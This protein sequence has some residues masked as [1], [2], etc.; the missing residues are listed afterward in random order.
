MK[1]PH[2][3]TEFHDS[4]TL[5][6]LGGDADDHWA[7]AQRTCPACRRF[8]LTLQR[9]KHPLFGTDRNG[10]QT[11]A[12]FQPVVDER[13]VKP[14]ASG[15]APCPTE[16]P[17]KFADDYLEACL[18]IAD[19]AKAA[20]ALGRRCLQNLLRE[21][22]GVKAGNL[23][24]EI[25]QVIDAGK[26]PSD[27]SESID[28]VRNIGNFAAHPMKS[29]NSGEIL[30][31]EPGEAEWTLDVV[32]GL[33]DYYFVRPAKIQQKKDALNKKLAEA[34]KPAMK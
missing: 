31:V 17:K 9:G 10:H 1:C 13:L 8:I 25:Q 32:E 26:L 20:G 28:A 27:L 33:F 11:F 6:Y 4:V 15:R 29:K 7:I 12:Q 3:L 14:K 5:H 23:A 19:S 16:V 34:G 22:A 30:D 21:L 24:D 2:C 18:T